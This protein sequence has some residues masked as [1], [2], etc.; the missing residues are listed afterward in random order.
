MDQL[1]LSWPTMGP[2]DHGTM[3]PWDHGNMGLWDHGTM[4][5][6]QGTMGPWHGTMGPWDHGTMRRAQ[7]AYSGALWPMQ[8]DFFASCKGTGEK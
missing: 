5:P 1:V 8:E 2:W 7:M 4:G 6:W 3:G